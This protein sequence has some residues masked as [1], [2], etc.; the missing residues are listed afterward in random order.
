MLTLIIGGAGSGKS[1][2]AEALL[3][4]CA[5]P[6]LYIATMQPLDAESRRRIARHRLQREGKGFLS[7]ECYTGLKGAAEKLPF[8]GGILLECAGNL[9]AN[10]LFSPEGGGAPA[11]REGIQAL[12]QR[13]FELIVVTNEVFSGGTDYEGD[14]LH[15]LW[16][17]AMLNRALAGEAER[18][19]EVICGCPNV[20]KGQLP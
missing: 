18:V 11:V 7:L 19:V 14:T 5:G 15:W 3:Q 13:C 12:R 8:Y 20:L 6:R 16:E 10:E 17:L 2:F 9:L 1:L 4:K